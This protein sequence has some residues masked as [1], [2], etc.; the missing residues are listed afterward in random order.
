MREMVK[1]LQLE[2]RCFD[3]EAM[4]TA[5]IIRRGY[6]IMEVPISHPARQ[7]QKISPLDSIPTIKALLRYCGWISK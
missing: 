5:K 4:I 1:G 7:V 3:V 6:C 2:C